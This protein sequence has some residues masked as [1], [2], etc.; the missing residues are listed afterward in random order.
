VTGIALGLAVAAGPLAAQDAAVLTGFVIDV[1]SGRPVPDAM[2]ALP[3]RS[4]EVM[5]DGEGAFQLTGVPRGTHVL[6]VRKFGYLDLSRAVAV[7]GSRRHLQLGLEPAPF[8]IEGLTVFVDGAGPITGRVVEAGSGAPLPGVVVWLAAERR[9]EPA[10]TTG[11]F[12][13]NDVPYGPQ[14]LQVLRAGYGPRM[15][16]LLHGPGAEPIEIALEPDHGILAAL[17]AVSDRLRGRRNGYLTVVTTHDTERLTRSGA[18]D[19][20]EYLSKYTLTRVVPCSGSAKSFWCIDFRG[21]PLEPE[22][23]IDGWLEWGGLDLL[24]RMGPNELHLLEVY[25]SSG[26]LIRAYTHEYMESLAGG[27][28]G[29]AGQE[30]T[31]QREGV[32]GLGW[33]PSRSGPAASIGPRC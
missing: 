32:E 4:L 18:E 26:A 33:A 15:I 22:V 9:G 23:C 16:P 5:T 8:G 13:V 14:V 2:V 30:P 11:Y 28:S 7:V 21:E 10:D 31:P 20:R 3:A 25:G 6:T 27:A 29:V 24:H 12:L 17:P 19:V 1:S